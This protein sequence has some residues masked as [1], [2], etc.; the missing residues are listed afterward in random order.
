MTFGKKF[1]FLLFGF[2]FI[3]CVLDSKKNMNVQTWLQL[4]FCFNK[5]SFNFIPQKLKPLFFRYCLF[6]ASQTLPGK[7]TRP[8]APS[9]CVPP[10]FFYPTAMGSNSSSLKLTI[11]CAILFFLIFLQ[12]LAKDA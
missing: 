3:N 1:C 5:F 2:V 4:Y 9:S 7:S 12:L 8:A 10:L 6:D 11:S